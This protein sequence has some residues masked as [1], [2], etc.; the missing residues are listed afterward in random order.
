MKF[1]RP[2]RRTIYAVAVVP[3]LAIVCQMLLWPGIRE[4]LAMRKIEAMGGIVGTEY[5]GPAW[6][7]GWL[8]D[9]IPT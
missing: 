8:G 6:I 7:R 9:P 5:R 1:R 3:G 4:Y 2:K